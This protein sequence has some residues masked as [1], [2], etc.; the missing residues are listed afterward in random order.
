MAPVRYSDAPGAEIE[1][2]VE[3]PASVVWAMVTDIELPARF[4]SELQ[5]VEWLD[6]VTGPAV[7]AA[8]AGRNRH[9]VLGEWRTVSHIVEL[10]PERAFGWVVVDA[11]GVFGDAP[12]DPDRPM[13]KW[14]FVLAPKAGHTLLRHSVRIGPA[15]SG[16]NLAI[17]RMPNQEEALVQHRLRELR[18]GM[19]ETLVGLKALAEAHPS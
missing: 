16:L 8:F 19:T 14:R 2:N 7:G 10:E 11:D 13:A 5:R 4:S 1:S 18:A 15:R 6:G 3:A 9:P 17:D 12:A